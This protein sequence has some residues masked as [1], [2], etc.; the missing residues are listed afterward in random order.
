MLDVQE[1]LVI[2][3]LGQGLAVESQGKTLLCQILK[4]IGQAAVGDQVRWK[5]TAPE[6]GRVIEILPRRSILI[7]PSRNGKTRP[8][9]ANIDKIMVVFTPKPTCDFLL[10][11][12]Y[13]AIC[14]NHNI[15]AELVFNKIDLINQTNT[16]TIKQQLQTYKNLK[17]P[18]HYVSATTK[19]NLGQ[20]KKTLHKH[21]CILVGQSGVGKSSLTNALIPSQ[22]LKTKPLSKGSK[23]GR[24][25]T[26]ATTLYHLPEGGNI[27]DS[28]GVAV[29]GLADLNKMQLAY[30]YREF[31]VLIG[32]CQFNN[33]QHL[34][35]KGCA[36]KNAVE[37][38]KICKQRYKRFLKLKQKM[39]QTSNSH[40]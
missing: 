11:D 18:I 20:L 29:F 32:Q 38:N 16:S 3:H 13:L 15:V 5:K 36:I 39:Q 27:I 12:Q 34:H 9:A 4:K 23:H 31:Q 2:A 6:Q 26:T 19:Q 17:Y 25:T 21:N 37:A 7:R 24:H 14:E 40:L 8:V 33:C 30:G 1:G 10:I 28:P 22:Q 35:D